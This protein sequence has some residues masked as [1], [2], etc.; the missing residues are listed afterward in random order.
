[1]CINLDNFSVSRGEYSNLWVAGDL[2]WGTQTHRP[3]MHLTRGADFR[4]HHVPI[5]NLNKTVQYTY[6][7]PIEQN[8]YWPTGL[9]GYYICI[10]TK[11]LLFMTVYPTLQK[12]W[13]RHITFTTVPWG[14]PCTNWWPQSILTWQFPRLSDLMSSLWPWSSTWC[15]T[16]VPTYI[17][18][19]YIIHT[20]IILHTYLGICK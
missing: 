19:Y 12:C 9:G 10:F 2:T 8:V 14:W 4:P 20:Y 18:L 3:K 1:M 15:P 16:Y 17:W 6:S 7:Y 5:A 11:F 13:K